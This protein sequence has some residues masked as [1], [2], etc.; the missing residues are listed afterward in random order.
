MIAVGERGG[1]P[2]SCTLIKCSPSLYGLENSGA[3]CLS[4]SFCHVAYLILPSL[5]VPSL[6]R[7]YMTG[8]HSKLLHALL[9]RSCKE[10]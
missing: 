4:F 5:V 3:V 9:T 2:S 10:V 6:I 7:V 1:C 8:L